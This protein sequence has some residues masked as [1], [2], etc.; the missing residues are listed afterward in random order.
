MQAG[1]AFKGQG[2]FHP[3]LGF[4]SVQ[5]LTDNKEALVMFQELVQFVPLT[6][7][8]TAAPMLEDSNPI[9]ELKRNHSRECWYAV[10]ERAEEQEAA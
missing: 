2:V 4:G 3:L 6:H 8:R 1:L 7:L 5:L 9:V 10:R